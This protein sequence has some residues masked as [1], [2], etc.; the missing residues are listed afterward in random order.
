MKETLIN[1][2]QLT[3]GQIAEIENY[4]IPESAPVAEVAQHGTVPNIAHPE[5]TPTPDIT[6]GTSDHIKEVAQRISS[7]GA[8]NTEGLRI[9]K[10]MGDAIQEQNPAKILALE[11]QLGLTHQE[12]IQMLN[13]T[14]KLGEVSFD[15]EFIH[16]VDKLGGTAVNTINT[17][18]A[19]IETVVV[20]SSQILEQA[21]T[22]VHNHINSLFGTKGFFGFGAVDG[23]NTPNWKDA[24]HGFANKTVTE[25]IQIKPE[26]MQSVAGSIGVDN[27]DAVIAIRKY[28]DETSFNSRVQ[29]L[30]G[31]TLANYLKRATAMAINSKTK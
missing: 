13:E 24:T 1:A 17:V 15:N 19:P 20:P 25:I 9:G 12:F 14:N 8:E 10:A 18:S 26:N 27:K 6:N 16:Q 4:T 22:Q 21:G 5:T 30:E 2:H 28:I 11:N 7:G 31:E 29:P 3:P 23:M